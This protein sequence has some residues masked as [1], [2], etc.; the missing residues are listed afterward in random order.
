MAD[1]SPK[2]RTTNL[3]FFILVGKKYFLSKNKR[4]K[5]ANIIEAV[6]FGILNLQN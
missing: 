5:D 2:E 6:R 4:T 3:Y 1:N